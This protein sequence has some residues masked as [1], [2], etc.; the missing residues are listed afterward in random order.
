[1][2]IDVALP[3]SEADKGTRFT[4]EKWIRGVGDRV[5]K[6]ET[7]LEVRSGTKTLRVPAPVGGL[8]VKIRVEEGMEVLAG[9]VV[10]MVEE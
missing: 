4:I 3:G 5:K 6:G 10:A 7:I 1:M 2:Q 9:V 8:L